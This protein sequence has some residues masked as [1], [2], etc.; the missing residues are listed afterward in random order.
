MT[1][2]YL[3]IDLDKIE[4]NARTIVGFC[5]KHGIEVAGVTKLACGHPE[6]AQAML[7]GGVTMIADSRLENILRLRQAGIAAPMMLL[8]LPPLS[9]VEEV[10]ASV[11][12]SLNS[13]FAVLEGLSHAAR[14][15]GT[16]HEVILMVD[17][18][19]LR[20]GV[21]PDELN[22]LV[23]QA[24]RL[25][26]INI[27]GLGANMACLAGV[28]PTEKTM[29]RLV[30]LADGL[31]SQLDTKLKWISG[32]NSSGLELI[33][34]GKMPKK[35]NHA[36]IGEAILLG[37]ETVHRNPWPDTH[38]DAFILH[39][40]VL[41]LKTKPSVSVGERSQDAFGERPVLE[42]RGTILRALVN[43]GREDVD[44]R[45]IK[46]IDPGLQVLGASSGYL[47]LDASASAGKI[48]VGEELSFFLN[49][50]ALLRAMTS[51]YVKKRPWHE[52]H[53]TR[54]A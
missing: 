38:Q 48:K 45:G 2:P 50:G 36:R 4:H 11:A 44:Q 40:E 19:D 13:E 23:E 39:A 14:K 12:I 49:Y 34:S 29:L 24:L 43:V 42:D 22:P 21:W 51:E 18:G 8:R 33:A 17:L 3:S 28:V 27:V 53:S 15:H 37:R 1:Y 31:E 47:V 5:G 6:V 54:S 32:I 20:E 52:S 26:G 9:G 46:P 16:R 25:P 41:E 10:V 35:I 30:S 7:R